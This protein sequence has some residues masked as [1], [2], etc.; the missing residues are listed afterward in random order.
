MLIVTEIYRF[1][2]NKLIFAK[3]N[4]EMFNGKYRNLEVTCGHPAV[5]NE[6]PIVNFD[7]LLVGKAK[8]G[9]TAPTFNFLEPEV[10]PVT[11][12]SF[13]EKSL[14]EID[15]YVALVTSTCGD[16]FKR[17]FQQE[18]EVD[19]DAM[20]NLPT[21]ASSI[22]STSPTLAMTPDSRSEEEESTNCYLNFDSGDDQEEDLLEQENLRNIESLFKAT[23]EDFV[24][25][26]KWLI[27]NTLQFDFDVRLPIT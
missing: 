21:P 9:Q 8:Q 5:K 15:L 25:S 13:S 20:E 22:Q 17:L 27:Q 2:G 24:P 16:K 11:T 3:S 14:Q 1:R 18:V 19:I 4:F 6:S 12:K 7:C 10:L 26:N 23:R